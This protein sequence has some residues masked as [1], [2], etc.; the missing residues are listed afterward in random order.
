MPSLL[1]E[2]SSE[3]RHDVAVPQLGPYLLHAT[4]DCRGIIPAYRDQS[5]S[6]KRGSVKLRRTAEKK[7][8]KCD[9]ILGSKEY[10]AQ[11]GGTKGTT[12]PTC[13][14]CVCTQSVSSYAKILP[15]C[16]LPCLALL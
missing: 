9:I 13:S 1:F 14:S 15:T 2:V 4:Q 7:K 8:D 6:F 3:Q 10:Q 5:P 16:V 11:N 12:A